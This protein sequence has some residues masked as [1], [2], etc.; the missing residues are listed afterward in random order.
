MTRL[1]RVLSGVLAASIAFTGFAQTAQATL[2]GTEQV[3]NAAAQTDA[4]TE[5]RAG[6][7]ERIGALLARD[8]VRTRLEGL[9]VDPARADAR[10]AALTDDEAAQL[11][12]TLD[13]APAGGDILGVIVLIFL[14]LLVTDILGFTKVYPFT[15]SIR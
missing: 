10:V 6:A 9:G 3:A 13:S 7:R 11:A 2:I 1:K 4:S 8:D 12:A 5:A 14:V 15:R